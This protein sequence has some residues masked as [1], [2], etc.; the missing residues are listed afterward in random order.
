MGAALEAAHP[1]PPRRALTEDQIISRVFG[2]QGADELARAL[3][4]DSSERAILRG[5]LDD[6]PRDALTPDEIK[7]RAIGAAQRRR[8]A[9]L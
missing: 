9:S 7:L 4:P 1:A 6:A 5:A 8:G 3:R 2:W